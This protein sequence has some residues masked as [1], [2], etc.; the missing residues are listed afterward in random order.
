[1]RRPARSRGRRRPSIR[2]QPYTITGAP[3][4]V[5]GKVIIGNGGAEYGV[6]GYV[7][8]Y[9]AET[10]KLAWRFYTVPGDPSKPQENTALE[11]ALPTWTGRLVEVRRRR[12]GV[13]L[14]RLRSRAESPLRR[15]RQRLAV[16]PPRAQPR[17]RRQPVS[18]VDRGAQPRHRRAGLALPDDAGRHVGLHRGAA[19]DARRSHHRRPP[20]QG[21]H[22][23]AEERLLLR[24]RSRDRR[25]AVGRQIRR[26]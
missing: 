13:G 15:H 20:A 5:K 3:R 18:L 21:D 14:D 4:I 2:T 22:A 9:D 11:R 10:G 8:A 16:E 17:R 19:D 24:A 23:G 26:R 6:R 1:M 12:H 7:S 25:V